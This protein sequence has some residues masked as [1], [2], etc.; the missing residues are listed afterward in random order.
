[1][2]CEKCGEECGRCYIRK[3][4]NG[5]DEVKICYECSDDYD[6]AYKTFI[7]E[8]MKTAKRYPFG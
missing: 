5:I 8:F 3:G 7:A 1:M 2:K 6:R 4:N